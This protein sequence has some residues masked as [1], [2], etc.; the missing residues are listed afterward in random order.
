MISLDFPNIKSTDGDNKGDDVPQLAKLLVGHKA[1]TE[2]AKIN[3]QAGVRNIQRAQER[4]TSTK[5]TSVKDNASLR[6]TKEDCIEMEGLTPLHG[7]ALQGD[8]ESINAALEA[9]AD[10]EG[11]SPDGATPLTLAASKGHH[12]AIKQLLASGANIDATSTNG[13]TALMMAVR[14]QDARTVIQLVCNGADINLLSPDRWT[15]L[16]EAS[17]QGQKEIM[18]ILVQCGAN[19][20]SRSAY[21]RTPLMHASYN[22]DE[23]AVMLLLEAGSNTEATSAHGETAMSLAAGGGYT[24][25]VRMLLMYGCVPEPAWAKD[26]KDSSKEVSQKAKAEET[27]E[28]EDKVLARG[29]TPLMHASQGGHVEIGRILLERNVNTEARSPHGKTALEIARENGRI[30]MASILEFARHDNAIMA[31]QARCSSV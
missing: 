13:R 25:I 18:R 17:Y 29:F 4:A 26:Q 22:G 5:D 30:D 24:N 15:A 27:G 8:L 9:G 23:A 1:D 14:R 12:D 10:I 11:F 6:G 19:T 2:K 7:A 21:D 3:H 16:T 31:R 28:P 20:E